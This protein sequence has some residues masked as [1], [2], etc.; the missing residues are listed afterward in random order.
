MGSIEVFE[1]VIDKSRKE[2]CGKFKA[3]EAY[4][5]WQNIQKSINAP[6]VPDDAQ[7]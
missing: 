5:C 6:I 3:L 1:T 7:P 4:H 2:K